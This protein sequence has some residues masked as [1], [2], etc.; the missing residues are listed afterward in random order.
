MKSLI[1]ACI[2]AIIGFCSSADVY[3]QC[4]PGWTP[5]QET[6]NYMVDGNCCAITATYC[7]RFVGGVIELKFLSATFVNEN[8]PVV[9]PYDPPDYSAAELVKMA[10][11]K[12]YLRNYAAITGLTLPNCYTYA[13]WAVETTSASCMVWTPVSRQILNPDGSTSGWRTYWELQPCGFSVGTCTRYCYACVL[14]SMD[15][16][17]GNEPRLQLNCNT[18]SPDICNPCGMP[19]CN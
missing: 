13:T 2:V 7:Y 18:V 5:K 10:T 9:D 11:E 3:A 19:I 12:F 16:C 15:V 4:A 8:C 6:F 14:P 17:N 1:V